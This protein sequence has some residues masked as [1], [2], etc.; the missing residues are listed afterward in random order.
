MIFVYKT[1][2]KINGNIYIGVHQTDDL[3]DEYFG[4]G[5]LINLALEEFGKE[6][7]EREI[8]QQFST[9]AEA[10][11]YEF[12]LVNR[13]FVNRSDT[14]NIALGGDGGWYH[15][16]GKTNV[17]DANGNT[18]QVSVND[19]RFLSGE[20]VGIQK[21]T[22]HTKETKSKMSKK[23]HGFV[24]VKDKFGNKFRVRKDDPKYLSGEYVFHSKNDSRTLK[25]VKCPH[26]GKEGKGGNMTRYHFI[27]CKFK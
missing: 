14:Y 9:L 3:N 7:F 25:L 24:P 5:D 4:S 19:P 6:N 23:N 21:G 13:E 17:K 8:L 27:N 11:S 1:T 18:M 26:C 12:K 10:Y 16:K 20:L 15:T 22:F 2:N